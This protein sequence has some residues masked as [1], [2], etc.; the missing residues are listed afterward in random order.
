[1][2]HY[3]LRRLGLFLLALVVTSLGI[4]ALLRVLPGD[5]AQVIGGIK[6][7]PEQ[8]ARIRTS[9]G[10]D[11]P[12]AAQY[13]DWVGGLLR[14]DLGDSLVTGSPIADQ[15]AEKL[16]VTIPLCLLAVTI[17]VVSGIPLGIWA[18]LRHDRPTGQV[19][20]LGSQALA[21]VPV[22]WAGLLLVILLSDGV[23]VVGLFPSQGFPLDGWAQPGRALR[24]LVLPALTIGL[25]EG[26]VIVR[27]V[28][29][30]V[31]EALPQDYLR[32]AAA[33]G[34]T[35]T[36]ALLRF[37]LPN[38]SLAVLSVIAL[39]AASMITGAVVVETLFA[40]PG[41]GSMLVGDVANRDL[42]KVQSSVL[43]LVALVLVVGL[44]LDV[45]QRAIDPRLRRRVVGA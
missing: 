11:R 44:V 33:K 25:V 26:A 23:G 34:M 13:L 3:V 2:F 8:L 45:A 16:Q 4:F 1:M 27:F 18:G 6:A 31:L 22:V 21:A 10:L 12:L 35:R 24:S 9:Y 15:L 20:S 40:L 42:V 17:A 36:G 5:V 19:I 38:V 41:I 29:S 7:T 32:T 39:Q 43:L 14:W 30:A 28:K 37:G